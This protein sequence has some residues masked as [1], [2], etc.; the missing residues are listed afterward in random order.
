MNRHQHSAGRL[1][2]NDAGAVID[3]ALLASPGV[4]Q[5]SESKPLRDGRW[6][7]V[8][9]NTWPHLGVT[10]QFV[11]EDGRAGLSVSL[12]DEHGDAINWPTGHVEKRMTL[13]DAQ[14][15]VHQLAHQQQADLIS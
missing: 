5:V 1:N 4:A 9:V 3:P 13:H 8:V 7:H 6:R 11:C 12:Y 2:A 10:A 14:R 15:L